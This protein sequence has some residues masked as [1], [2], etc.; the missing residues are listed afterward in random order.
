MNDLSK[1]EEL[2]LI[3]VLKLKENAYGVTIKKYF[4]DT[5]GKTI[6]YGS[7][8]KILY[9]LVRRGYIQSEESAPLAQQGGR[10][11]V[12]Y[13]LTDDGKRVLKQAYELQKTVWNSVSDI[14]IEFE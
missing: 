14:L 7:L 11:K 5:T 10:R 8:C 1:N 2:C 4:L 12:M 9:K 6:N 3:A 13:A